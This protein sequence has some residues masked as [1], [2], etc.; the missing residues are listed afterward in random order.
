MGSP[1][2]SGE[3]L[4]EESVCRSCDGLHGRVHPESLE[5]HIVHCPSYIWGPLATRF[6][7]FGLMKQLVIVLREA[8]VPRDL[9]RTERLRG[10]RATDRSRPGDVV[11]GFYGEDSHLVIDASVTSVYISQLDSTAV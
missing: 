6:T 3:Q 8:G 7:L 10:L 5:R 2:L 9:I 4:D 1:A 11:V